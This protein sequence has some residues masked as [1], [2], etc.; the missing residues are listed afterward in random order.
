MASCSSPIKEPELTFQGYL[1]H[2]S[3]RYSGGSL[4]CGTSDI[5]QGMDNQTNPEVIPCLHNAFLN[6]QTAHGYLTRQLPNL[7]LLN[8]IGYTTSEDAVER[9]TYSQDLENPTNLSL[10]TGSMC[11]NPSVPTPPSSHSY[12]QF[13]CES[14]YSIY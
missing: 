12:S 6:Q 11:E 8:W 4:D 1:D 10:M 14:N 13:D 9:Y 5:S 2:V 7:G 3:S